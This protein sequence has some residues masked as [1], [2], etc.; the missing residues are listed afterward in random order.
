VSLIGAARG[1]AASLRFWWALIFIAALTALGRLIPATGPWEFLSTAAAILVWGYE[2]SVSRGVYDGEPVLPPLAEWTP[3]VRRALSLTLV[4]IVPLLLPFI[5]VG[6]A[7][8]NIGTA[9]P[10]VLIP[11]LS[12]V[13]FT[14]LFCIFSV[15]Y[16]AFDR[17][18]D[19][20]RYRQAW[21]RFRSNSRAG[22]RVIG[23]LLLGEAFYML[24]DAALAQ[25]NTGRVGT[26]VVLAVLNAPVLLLGAHLQGQ[27]VAIAYAAERA[28]F[29]LTSA[30]WLAKATRLG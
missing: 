3:M 23:Y 7:A 25:L 18:R 11:I 4:L 28:G 9:W 5:V 22:L 14:P 26:A 30:S 12:A 29:G 27:Y 19:G 17:L 13:M 15:P 8:V 16:I 1:V 21:W 24:A 20:F 6:I 10:S 2:L